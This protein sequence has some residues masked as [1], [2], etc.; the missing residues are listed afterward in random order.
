MGRL[1]RMEGLEGLAVGT[2][3]G[4]EPSFLVQLLE[5]KLGHVGGERGVTG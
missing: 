5:G 1:S 2:E 4:R 3:K